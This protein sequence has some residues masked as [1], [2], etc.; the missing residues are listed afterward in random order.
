[1]K[2]N[3]LLGVCAYCDEHISD[4]SFVRHNYTQSGVLPFSCCDNFEPFAECENKKTKL[5]YEK[6]KYVLTGYKFSMKMRG[7]ENVEFLVHHPVDGGTGWITSECSTGASIYFLESKTK[8]EAIFQAVRM[9][10][11]KGKNDG[12]TVSKFLE[13]LENYNSPNNPNNPNNYECVK[14]A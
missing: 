14:T 7:L 1:M 11:N 5:Y 13:I 3:L 9:L 4:H 6:N 12:M 10:Y 8:D 2:N